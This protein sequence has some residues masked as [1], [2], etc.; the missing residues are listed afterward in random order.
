M[1]SRVRGNDGFGRV[2]VV[3]HLLCGLMLAMGM[4]LSAEQPAFARD[5]LVVALQ[6]EPPTLDPTS[7]AAAAIDE[8]TYRTIFEGLTTL[9]ATGRAVP[10]LATGWTMAPDARS[11][12]FHLRAGVRFTDG[13]PFDA[14]IVAFRLMRAI[15][16]ESTS[17]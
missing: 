4:F 9:D 8:V 17:A 11:Y 16:P 2:K 13:T 6:L 14:S 3:A 10:L 5:S 12:V 1:D 15:H 7:G